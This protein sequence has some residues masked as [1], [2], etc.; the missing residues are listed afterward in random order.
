MSHYLLTGAS[1]FVG[2]RL[3]E[4]LLKAGHSVAAVARNPAWISSASAFPQARRKGDRPAPLTILQGDLGDPSFVERIWN[5]AAP[6][7]GIFHFAAMIPAE[8]KGIPGEFT[9]A[10]YIHNNVT[11]TAVLL[12]TIRKR[13]ARVPFLYAS[14]ISVFGKADYLPIMEDHPPSPADMYG[15]SK[16]QGEEVLRLAAAGASVHG[17]VL[18]YPG[19][20]GIGNDYGAVHYYVSR[21]L[22]GEHIS[23]YGGGRPQK[24]Y[25]AVED[26]AAAAELAMHHAR[27][28]DYE[29]FHVGGC[30]PGLPPPSLVEVARLAAQ[31][32]GTG[33]VETN[34]RQPAQPVNMY[35]DNVKAHA[36]LGFTPRPLAERIRDYV[37]QR[38]SA[39]V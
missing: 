38:K 32:F 8:I 17:V 29:I 34:D 16:L 24:D 3:L 11:T 19:M 27:R 1:G 39:G 26:V 12:D 36:L 37:A 23:V 35:F 4:L 30:T 13:G 20:I 31:A 15:L 22:A 9:S 6:F 33:T 18:R 5:E 25:I 28:F 21:L 7:D 2:C 10:Q 14:S